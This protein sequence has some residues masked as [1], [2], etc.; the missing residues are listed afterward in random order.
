MSMTKDK[1]IEQFKKESAF[2]AESGSRLKNGA[3][4][5]LYIAAYEKNPI[6]KK[7]DLLREAMN[8]AGLDSNRASRQR[9]YEIHNRLSDELEKR[10]LRA[11]KDARRLGLNVILELAQNADSESVKAQ[12]ALA[13]TKD[14]MPDIQITKQETIED[15]D[16]ELE[17]LETELQQGIH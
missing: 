14:L 4:D 8:A 2:Y 9:A 17:Q 16:R 1:A 11:V 7:I 10:L 6:A 13:I 3:L 15:I 12:C 5:E